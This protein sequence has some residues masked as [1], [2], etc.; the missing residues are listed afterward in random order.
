MY[1]HFDGIYPRIY[2][3]YTVPIMNPME[4]FV[5]VL[6]VNVQLLFGFQH[7]QK[8]HDNVEQVLKKSESYL[9]QDPKLLQKGNA[10]QYSDSESSSSAVDSSDSTSE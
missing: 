4:M 10:D 8:K 9:F 3:R 7:C 6:S 5:P 1:K 2:E